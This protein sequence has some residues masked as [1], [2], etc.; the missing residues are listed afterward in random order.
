MS[1]VSAAG[2]GQTGTTTAPVQP[3]TMSACDDYRKEGQKVWDKVCDF[4][5]ARL[6]FHSVRPGAR[7]EQVTVSEVYK[8]SGTFTKAYSGTRADKWE[9]KTGMRAFVFQAD[10][11]DYGKQVSHKPC[12]EWT[13]EMSHMLKWLVPH[14]DNHTMVMLFDGRSKSCRRQLEDWVFTNYPEETKQAELWVTYAGVTASDD[15]REPRRRVAFSDTCRECVLVGLPIPKVSMKTKTRPSY[16]SEGGDVST[17]S[18]IYG[19]VPKRSLESLPRLLRSEKRDMIGGGE[20][21]ELPKDMADAADDGGGQALFWSEVKIVGFLAQ[22]LSDFNVSHV[23]DLSPASGAVAAAAALN[24][25]TCDAFCFNDM[26]KQWLEGVMDRAMLRVLTQAEG[27]RLGQGEVC[28]KGFSEE[29]KKYFSSSIRDAELL[30][31][32]DQRSLPTRRGRIRRRTRQRSLSK[33]RRGPRR[34]LTMIC[35]VMTQKLSD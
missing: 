32:L 7:P 15:P 16:T 20:I 2:E 23:V 8:A 26:H 35:Q 34:M 30:L 19:A 11:F 9:G 28:E 25:I 33:R 4:R 27:G 22:V 14:K 24:H 1:A 18:Q 6:R 17:H 10:C 31:S 5:R 3:G 12:V 13:D 29:I 21:E